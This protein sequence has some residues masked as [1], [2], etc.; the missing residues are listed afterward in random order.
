MPSL[1]ASS[2]LSTLATSQPMRSSIASTTSALTSLSSASSTRRDSRGHVAQQPGAF[3]RRRV[4]VRLHRCERQIEHEQ[5]A[6]AEFA[7]AADV[8]AHRPRHLARNAQAEAGAAGA[9]APGARAGRTPR[10]RADRSPGAMPWPVSRTANSTTSLSAQPLDVQ[11]DLPG[12]GE[13]QRIAEQVVQH[14]AQP[15]RV[16]LHPALGAELDVR[17]KA[18][19]LRSW[20][21]RSRCRSAPRARR[22]GRTPAR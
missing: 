19:P 11:R 16:A 7:L 15:G 2:P 14:L 3:A 4:R 6:A 1:T 5:R 12:I 21:A 9:A 22:A 17:R 18:E 20:R 8:A 13:L 10:T